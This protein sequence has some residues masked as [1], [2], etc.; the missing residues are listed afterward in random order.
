MEVKYSLGKYN[1]EAD[2][3]SRNPVL[4]SE[5]NL[6]QKLKIVNLIRLEE[7]LEDQRKNKDVQK[8]QKKFPVKDGVYYKQ[9]EKKNNP[10]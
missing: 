7:I 5:E 4:A 3:L 6:D 10:H 8:S 2:C 1:L 9:I